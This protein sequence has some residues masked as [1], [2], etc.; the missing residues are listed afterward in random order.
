[1]KLLQNMSPFQNKLSGYYNYYCKQL[2][3]TLNKLNVQ[4]LTTK[5]KRQKGVLLTPN[6]G[7]QVKPQ[8]SV[9]QP[10]SV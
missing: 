9:A 8:H 1:M 6:N 7:Q 5:K 4:A 10:V 2:L 3:K